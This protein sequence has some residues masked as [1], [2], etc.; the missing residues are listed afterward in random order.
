MIGTFPSLFLSFFLSLPVSLNVSVCYP[1]PGKGG[2][3]SSILTVTI[4]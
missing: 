1:A 2:I 3:Y 4:L